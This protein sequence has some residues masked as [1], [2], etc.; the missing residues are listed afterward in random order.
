MKTLKVKVLEEVMLYIPSI[1]DYFH[2]F[3]L[4]L[5]ILLVFAVSLPYNHESSQALLGLFLYFDPK[6]VVEHI[7][8]H[9]LG[10]VL[11]S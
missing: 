2:Q 6:E 10:F 5:F 3:C 7:E 4:I 9:Y 11:L 1:R 8:N